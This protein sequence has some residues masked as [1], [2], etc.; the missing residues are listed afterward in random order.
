MVVRTRRLRTLASLVR[1]PTSRLSGG[2]GRG[3]DTP[4]EVRRTPRPG[5]L[6]RAPRQ[7]SPPRASGHCPP[8]PAD[9]RGDP[10]LPVAG[11]RGGRAV[12]PRE[13]Q[14]R[15]QG[16]SRRRRPAVAQASGRPVLALDAVTPRPVALPD[17]TRSPRGQAPWARSGSHDPARPWREW[18]THRPPPAGAGSVVNRC[19]GGWERRGQ[20][21]RPPPPDGPTP[22]GSKE[23]LNPVADTLPAPRLRHRRRYASCRI[24]KNLRSWRG[25]SAG[26]A[27]VL[28]STDGQQRPHEYGLLLRDHSTP[29]ASTAGVGDR[30]AE[31]RRAADDLA[32]PGGPRRPVSLAAKTSATWFERSGSL[33]PGGACH[34][35]YRKSCYYPTQI[36]AGGARVGPR[37]SFRKG[38]GPSGEPLP[39]RRAYRTGAPSAVA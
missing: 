13:S 37:S 17:A 39:P 38:G 20:T 3:L 21:R 36:G 26:R 19:G 33:A 4:V 5:E 22:P 2:G 1:L 6:R 18:Q 9:R 7:P 16:P 30:L 25:L 34:T 31:L 24:W 14:V 29:M 11:A 28:Q 27:R 23:S 15:P 10:A 12:P 8:L 35:A 32:P